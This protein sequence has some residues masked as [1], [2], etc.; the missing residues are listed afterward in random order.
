MILSKRAQNLLTS[1][2]M[3]A[4]GGSTSTVLKSYVVRS[5]SFRRVYSRPPSR[6]SHSS[7]ADS[8]AVTT[9]SIPFAAMFTCAAATDDF[10]ISVAK[11]LRNK[12]ASAIVKCPLPQ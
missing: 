7:S 1:S 2:P 8:L 4:R 5:I 10:D 9:L 11:H 12:G 3:P 6:A